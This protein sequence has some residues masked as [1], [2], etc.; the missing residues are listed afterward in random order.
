MTDH[1]D[2]RIVEVVS[3]LRGHHIS[4]H[5]SKP[6]DLWWGVLGP[7]DGTYTLESTLISCGFVIGYS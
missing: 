5:A 3:P 4:N 6:L 2:T 1:D 7:L